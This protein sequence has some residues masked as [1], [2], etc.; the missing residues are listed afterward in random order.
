VGCK[1][2]DLWDIMLVISSQEVATEAPP[3]SPLNRAAEAGSNH[4]HEKSHGHF[5]GVSRTPIDLPSGY[6]TVCY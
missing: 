1:W 5:L 6:L 2:E 3:D 4:G